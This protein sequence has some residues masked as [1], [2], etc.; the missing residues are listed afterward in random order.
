MEPRAGERVRDSIVDVDEP[1]RHLSPHEACA[2][3]IMLASGRV[4]EVAEVRA[5][6]DKDDPGI[7]TCA[8]HA[9]RLPVHVEAVEVPGFSL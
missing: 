1:R 5:R 7:D 2:R 3:R 8:S 4:Y 6:S 9:E